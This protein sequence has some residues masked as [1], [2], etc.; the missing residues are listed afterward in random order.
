MSIPAEPTPAKLI[1]GIFTGEKKCFSSVAKELVTKFGMADITSQWI[2]FN[3]T[4]YYASEMGGGLFRRIM[5]FETLIGQDELS[6]IKLFTNEIEKRHAESGNRIVNIDPGY[7]LPSR[8][9][10]ATGKDYAH[11]VYIGKGIYADLTLMFGKGGVQTLPWTYP[12]YADKS[13][14]SYLECVRN[15][16]IKDLKSGDSSLS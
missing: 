8:F 14:I 7:M 1:I 4:S 12:D 2:P 16:Y 11:R 10:L 13:I 5:S 9:I 6:E 15:K 3:Y